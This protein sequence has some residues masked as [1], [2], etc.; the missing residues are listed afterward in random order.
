MFSFYDFGDV[1]AT[2]FLYWRSKITTAQYNLYMSS[3][4]NRIY[5]SVSGTV[6]FRGWKCKFCISDSYPCFLFH[7]QQ[8][9]PR[10][11]HIIREVIYLLYAF[12]AYIILFANLPE[13]IAAL[14]IVDCKSGK[15]FDHF[16][17]YRRKF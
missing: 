8:P 10:L 4:P 15:P 14:Y 5:T 1:F 2:D 17:G 12:H 16:D 11:Y 7:Y 3:M 9:I 13:R 6:L